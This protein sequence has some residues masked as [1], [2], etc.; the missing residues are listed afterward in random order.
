[1][2]D[3]QTAALADYQ[4]ALGYA[5]AVL[6]WFCPRVGQM[7]RARA[8]LEQSLGLLRAQHA[9][10]ALAY[11]LGGA[12]ALHFVAGDFAQCEQY[13]LESL[14]LYRTLGRD[15]WMGSCHHFLSY[16]SLAQGR[17]AEAQMHSGE[18]L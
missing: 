13:V 10:H 3:A 1:Q 4:I 5:L 15:N 6:G 12:G 11:A 14:Q 17:L 9:P 7:D 16:A 2:V 18:A 8:A